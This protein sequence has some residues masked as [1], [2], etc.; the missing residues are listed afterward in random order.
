MNLYMHIDKNSSSAKAETRRQNAESRDG[1]A[2]PFRAGDGGGLQAPARLLWVEAPQWPF[3]GS[4]IRRVQNLDTGIVLAI[5]RRHRGGAAVVLR[6]LVRVEP[7][8][9]MVGLY[10]VGGRV[11]R[12]IREWRIVEDCRCRRGALGK[13]EGLDIET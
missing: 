2:N 11:R 3:V 4:K 10:W 12:C 9:Q 5:E 8:T 7:K 1:R 6:V 13:D